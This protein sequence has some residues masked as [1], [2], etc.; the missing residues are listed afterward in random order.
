MSQRSA[1][2]AGSVPSR[3]VN[4]ASSSVSVM[5]ILSS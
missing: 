2:S 1:N 3:A 5:Q 4:A